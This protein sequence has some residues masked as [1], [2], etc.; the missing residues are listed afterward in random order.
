MVVVV[1]VVVRGSVDFEGGG[2][3]IWLSCRNALPLTTGVASFKVVA[4]LSVYCG[5]VPFAAIVAIFS[6]GKKKDPRTYLRIWEREEK[7]T[8]SINEKFCNKVTTKDIFKIESVH[9]HSVLRHCQPHQDRHDQQPQYINGT[10]SHTNHRQR[11]H[12]A[13]FQTEDEG[14]GGRGI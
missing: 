13:G 9:P 3:V 7:H 1:V 12:D 11:R 14:N 6:R 4:W 5:R 2:R 8:R 10:T